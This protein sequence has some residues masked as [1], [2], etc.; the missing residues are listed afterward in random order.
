MNSQLQNYF[1]ILLLVVVA[2]FAL[3]TKPAAATFDPILE[4]SITNAFGGDDRN[5][6]DRLEKEIDQLYCTFGDATCERNFR[7]GHTIEEADY[8]LLRHNRVTY[9]NVS[10]ANCIGAFSYW[11]CFNG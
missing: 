2:G 9:Q 1:F 5:G 3:M 8:I 11:I 10:V 7:A 4:A 6:D